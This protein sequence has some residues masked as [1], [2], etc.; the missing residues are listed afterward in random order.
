MLSLKAFTFNPAQ[1]NTYILYNEQMDCCIIDPGCYFDKERKELT[2]FIHKTGLKPVRLLNTHCHLD[3][4][5]G[6]N[7]VYQTWGLELYIHENEKQVLDFAPV[8]GEMWQTPLDVYTGPLHFLKE[9]EEILL[10]NDKMKILFTPGHSPGSVSFYDEEQKFVISG[11]VLFNRSIG[12]TDLPGCS[13]DDLMNSIR[14]Q[15]FTLPDD[16]TVFSGHGIETTIGAEKRGNPFREHIL[17]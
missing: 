7:Y 10:G 2:E 12:R 16:V 13:F 14:T 8:S 9:G 1:E 3:H 11:D 6:N 4:V 5:Y 15:L 17:G